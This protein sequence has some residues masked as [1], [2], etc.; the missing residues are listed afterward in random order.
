MAD[1]TWKI[2]GHAGFGIMSAGLIFSKA[3]SRGGYHVFDYSEYP[4]LIRGG[5]NTHQ[6]R[7]SS[8]VIH[9]QNL[10]VHILVALNMETIDRHRAELAD[11]GVIIYDGER[12]KDVSGGSAFSVPFSRLAKESG[13]SEL[14]A[15]NVALG[16]SVGLLGYDIGLLKGVIADVFS[17]KGAGVVNANVGAAVAGYNYVRQNFR[18]AF[19]VSVESLGSKRKYLL[20]GNEAVGAGAI[21]AGCKFYAGYPMTPTSSLLAYM[22]QR[23]KDFGI[24]VKQCEDEIS[25]INTAI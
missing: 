5:H 24:V 3:F 15:N 16:A 14:M 11:G 8:R 22:S 2:G 19:G 10:P 17:A 20:T 6:T 13:G 7:V 12:L 21:A 25:V 1:F 23:Q 18:K 9:S 4:S